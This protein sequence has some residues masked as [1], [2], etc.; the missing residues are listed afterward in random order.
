MEKILIA[1]DSRNLEVDTVRFACHLAK[2]TES[3]LTA[4]FLE[5]ERS[6][7]QMAF[8]AIAGPDA[9]VE[10]TVVELEWEESQVHHLRDKNIVRF[11]QFTA[12]EGVLSTVY[13]DRGVP[14]KDLITESLFADVL[15]LGA[16][17]FSD[18]ADEPPTDFVKRIVHDSGCPVIIAPETF[19]DIDDILFCY[20]G[21]RSCLHAMKQFAYLFPGLTGQRVKV[22]D[23]KPEEPE[24]IEQARVIAWLK[25]HF[26][27]V[28]WIRLGR[29]ETEAFFS[30]LREKA[31]DLVVMGAYGKGLLASF[32]TEDTGL[33][34]VRTTPV[35]LFIAHH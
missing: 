12:E 17:T 5:D 29:L 34:I 33:G 1:I 32:F 4:V 26:E 3:K 9:L 23:L 20:E 28:E 31:G 18:F 24:P 25:T 2:I 10:R 15:V 7:R 27:E 8:A 13:L 14:V 16:N 19:N 35:P 6:R 30:F 11:K 22:I 21:G